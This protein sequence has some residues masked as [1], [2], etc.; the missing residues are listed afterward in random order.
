MGSVERQYRQ[1]VE[2]GLAL[3]AHLNLPKPYWEDAFL[4]TTYIINRLPSKVLNNKSPFEMTYNQKLKYLFVRVFGCAYWPNLRA[5]NEHKIDFCSKTCIFLGYNISHQG[6][7]C[8][9]LATGK[10]YVSRHVIF[11]EFLFPYQ[12][13]SSTSSL[14]HPSTHTNHAGPIIIPTDPLPNTQVIPQNQENSDIQLSLLRSDDALVP[15]KNS[16]QNSSD[17]VGTG[18]NNPYPS[19]NPPRPVEQVIH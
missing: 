19:T 3:L 2:M 16:T 18:N 9:D 10:I 1:I 15:A 17:V 5:F 14:C 11:D 8:L 6:Y 7:K 4:T 13:E 12:K